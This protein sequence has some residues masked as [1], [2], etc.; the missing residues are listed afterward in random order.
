MTSAPRKASRKQVN[1]HRAALGMAPI[2]DIYS[3][4]LTERPLL[5]CDEVLWPVPAG[6]APAPLQ[7]GYLTLPDERSLSRGLEAFVDDGERP[8]YVGF[9]LTG[10]VN[11]DATTRLI[12]EALR[13]AGRH[14]DRSSGAGRPQ[15]EQQRRSTLHRSAGSADVPTQATCA[16]QERQLCC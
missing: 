9:G 14:K 4:V 16:K 15:H 8:V 13:I 2:A 3:H 1:A 11:A 7:V 6:A 12:V 10:E 5:A